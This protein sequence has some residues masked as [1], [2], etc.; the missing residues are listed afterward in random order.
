MVVKWFIA[1]QHRTSREHLE[2]SYRLRQ[3]NTFFYISVKFWRKNSCHD[4]MFIWD[5]QWV[6]VFLEKN[7]HWKILVVTWWLLLGF[8]LNHIV[9]CCISMIFS[10][11]LL[12]DWEILSGILKTTIAL[13]KLNFLRRKGM[14][15]RVCMHSLLRQ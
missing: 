4:W 13:V 12:G 9:K 1:K 7:F 3:K 10:Q 14:C 5:G 15:N 2:H 11:L 8:Q 6:G